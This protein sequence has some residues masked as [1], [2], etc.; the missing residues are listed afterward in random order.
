MAEVVYVQG[1]RELHLKFAQLPGDLQKKGL[2]GALSA[3]AR[4]ARDAARALA[5]RGKGPK[6]RNG[7]TVPA[8]TLK[9]SALV[10]F[11]RKQSNETQ[12]VYIVTFRRGKKQQKGNRDAYYASWVEFGH[13]IVP[14]KAKASSWKRRRGLV[15]RFSLAGRRASATGTVAGKRFLTNSFAAGQERYVQT[16]ERVLRTKFD[17]AVR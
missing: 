6:R 3:A 14:R 2:R 13:R 5:P 1:L 4:Q 12:A 8:G 10:S 11:D 15:S 16:F 7:Q 9:R 17:E